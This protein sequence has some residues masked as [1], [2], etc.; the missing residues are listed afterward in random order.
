MR[1]NER[2]AVAPG[3]LLLAKVVSCAV[4]VVKVDCVQGRAATNSVQME[5]SIIFCG[6]QRPFLVNRFV[7]F[8][9]DCMF[10]KMIML[11]LKCT[12]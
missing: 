8:L 7:T 5:V 6:Y 3:D 2:M 10:G 9:L 1:I 4:S 11:H 12:L